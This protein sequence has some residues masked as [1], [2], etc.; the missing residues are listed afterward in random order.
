MGSW[1]I[2]VVVVVMAVLIGWYRGTT[3]FFFRPVL[4]KLE[5]ILE[6]LD[7]IYNMLH[8]H[9][10]RIHALDINSKTQKRYQERVEALMKDQLRELKEMG[11]IK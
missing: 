6:K 7:E 2:G 4:I 10:L 1:I 8:E 5:D 11:K 3:L 9:D